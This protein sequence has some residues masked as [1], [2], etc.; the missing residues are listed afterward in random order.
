MLGILRIIVGFTLLL[1]IPGFVFSWALFPDKRDPSPINRLAISFVLSIALV[2]LIVLFMDIVLGIPTNA[3]NIAI[4][5]CFF[6]LC[7]L[8]YIKIREKIGAVFQSERS[9]IKSIG[10]QRSFFKSVKTRISNTIPSI[11]E[12]DATERIDHPENP[13]NQNNENS[14]EKM[15]TANFWDMLKSTGIRSPIRKKGKK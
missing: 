8:G 10:I 7:V 1:F 2:I 6:S 4:S 3:L 11:H 12:Y 9:R 5:I 14:P 13:N 15:E